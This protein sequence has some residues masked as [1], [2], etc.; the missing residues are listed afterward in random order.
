MPFSKAA[1][2]IALAAPLSSPNAAMLAQKAAAASA[3][4][5]R[6]VMVVDRDDDDVDGT[7]DREQTKV[8]DSAALF[9]VKAR[10][11]SKETAFWESASDGVRLLADGKVV[12]TGP[13]PLP[14]KTIAL[15]AVKPG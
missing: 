4:D 12:P 1:A 11:L 9:V 10:P 6:I 5:N 15:Q 7:P 2:A 8:P 3:S 14:S 13:V